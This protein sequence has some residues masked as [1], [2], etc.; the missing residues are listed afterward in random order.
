M[1]D[2]IQMSQLKVPLVQDDAFEGENF[3]NEYVKPVNARKK[4]VT[5]AFI[6]LGVCAVVGIVIGK[7]TVALELYVVLKIMNI[8]YLIF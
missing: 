7:F 5:R 1:A 3:G 6:L 2:S 4:W 8:R